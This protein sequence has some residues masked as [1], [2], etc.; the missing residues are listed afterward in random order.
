MIPS[1][2]HREFIL[3]AIE[4]V[5]FSGDVKGRDNVK[6]VLKLAEECLEAIKAAPLGKAS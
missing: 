6:A 1:E 4:S 5:Q 3:R 2:T